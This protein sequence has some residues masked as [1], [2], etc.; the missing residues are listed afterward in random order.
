MAKYIMVRNTRDFEGGSGFKYETV[1]DS[2]ED[3]DKYLSMCES[4]M[5]GSPFDHFSRSELSYSAW[6]D[7]SDEADYD[8][9]S[10]EWWA[11]K[12]DDSPYVVIKTVAID[13]GGIRMETVGADTM[14][15]ASSIIR[16]EYQ[17]EMRCPSFYAGWDPEYCEIDERHAELSVE[18]RDSVVHMTIADTKSRSFTDEYF[19]HLS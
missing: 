13:T 18:T 2:M 4:Y 5:I 17:K 10:V 12:V 9:E 7:Y 8:D 14:E 1:L 3:V 19:E 16:E 6:F 11:E 15:D